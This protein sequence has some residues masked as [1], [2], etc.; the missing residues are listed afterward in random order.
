MTEGGSIS[1]QGVS[2]VFYKNDVG[3]QALQDVSFEVAPGE[4][5]CLIGP[6][7]CGKSTLL[8]LIG[9]LDRPTDGDIQV[10]GGNEESRRRVGLMLQSPT[11]LPWRTVR[12]NILLPIELRRKV[13]P[14]DVR[15]ADDLIHLVGLDGFENHY[16]KELSGGMQ[17]RVA[18]CR[19]LI[20]NPDIMLLDEPFGA[21]DEFTRERLNIELAETVASR[22]KTAV[23]VTHNI[24]EAVFLADKIFPMLSR[25]GRMAPVIEVPFE[26]PRSTSLMRTEAFTKLVFQVR[27]ALGLG[28]T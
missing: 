25:P 11:L 21:L 23:L 13:T 17:Q 19:L 6:S 14:E 7:G 28:E 12:S 15:A 3:F 26:R 8:R 16:P 1:A 10:A 2:R 4:F 24:V 22:R 5:A 9:G 18:L 20:I 27:E